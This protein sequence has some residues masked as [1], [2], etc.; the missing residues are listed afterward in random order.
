VPLVQGG[1]I[2]A[3]A[4]TGSERSSEFPDVPSM[5]EAGYPEVKH[6]SLERLICFGEHPACDRRQT[7]Y[8]VAPRNG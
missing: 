3:L 4:V 7:R 2:R 1:K 5:A 6:R 8:G